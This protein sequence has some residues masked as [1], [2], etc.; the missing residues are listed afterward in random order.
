[1]TMS[2][3]LQQCRL[4][5]A[6]LLAMTRD[7]LGISRGGMMTE[8]LCWYGRRLGLALGLAAALMGSAQ[9]DDSNSVTMGDLVLFPGGLQPLF[10][11]DAA[12]VDAEWT[13]GPAGWHMPGRSYRAGDGWWALLCTAEVR[14]EDKGCRLYG[15]R[16]SVSRAKHSVYDGDAVDSQLLHWSPLPGGL[17]RVSD[18]RA[19]PNQGPSA[20]A[21]KPELLALF[22]PVRSLA[23]L[24]FSEGPVTT[25][26]HAGMSDYP[27]TPR[28]G[29]MEVRLA[30]GSGN[31]LDIVPR[32]QPPAEPEANRAENVSIDIASFE[33][34][35]GRQRQSLRGYGFS[36]ID[37]PG[38]LSRQTYL[39][40]AGDLDGDGR[41]DLL[42]SH[43]ESSAQLSLYLS[44]L[45]KAGELV[46]LA[47]SFDYY[48][49]SDSGC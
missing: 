37:G 42:M 10:S 3:D 35:R 29:T 11:H 32:I 16:L 40:W 14:G 13:G 44:S 18:N 45:A 8:M 6:S 9:A 49:P 7:S 34:R 20:T 4:G 17:D 2:A 22:K 25:Y 28:P 12:N 19:A 36:A 5:C 41:P 31:Y 23:H 30:L 43:G 15:T 48:D 26:V 38:Q 1:M 39:R 47:G 24:K 27:A 33:L 46:G 21:Q